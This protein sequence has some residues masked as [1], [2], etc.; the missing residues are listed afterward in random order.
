VK[1][2]SKLTAYKAVRSNQYLYVQYSS[3]ERE[4][5]DLRNDPDELHNMIQQAEPSL[6]KRFSFWLNQ[7]M[8][9]KGSG[10]RQV[11]DANSEDLH[12]SS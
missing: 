4:L 5:Y 6:I 9:C 8:Q 2:K 10:C 7:L 12:L 1:G 3:G 11:E